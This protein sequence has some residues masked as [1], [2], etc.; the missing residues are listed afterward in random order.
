MGGEAPTPPGVCHVPGA[1]EVLYAADGHRWLFPDTGDDRAAARQLVL[2]WHRRARGQR[3]RLGRQVPVHRP[4]QKAQDDDAA[5]V[6][7][8]H[9]HD[10]RG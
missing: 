8:R 5:H 4:A 1:P 6:G 2:R 10:L 9:R 3:A 7:R